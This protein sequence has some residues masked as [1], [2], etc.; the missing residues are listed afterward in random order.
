MNT[1]DPQAEYG[2][3]KEPMLSDGAIS[4]MA[5]LAMVNC[6]PDANPAFMHVLGAMDARY[7]Y[8]HLIATGKLRVVVEVELT[9]NSYDCLLTCSGCKEGV[10]YYLAEEFADCKYCPSCGSIIRP[11]GP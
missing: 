4:A 7:F 8:E 9:P 10:P 3:P 2:R 11:T 1:N 5:Q 6:Q